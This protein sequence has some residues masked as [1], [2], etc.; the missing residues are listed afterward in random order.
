MFAARKGHV[1]AT[2]ALI[3]AGATTYFDTKECP[4][5]TRVLIDNA[6]KLKEA[7]EKAQRAAQRAAAKAAREKRRAPFLEKLKGVEKAAAEVIIKNLDKE[8][9]LAFELGL[10]MKAEGEK[11]AAEFL[12]A[13]GDIVD[14]ALFENKLTGFYEGYFTL[15]ISGKLYDLANNIVEGANKR[16]IKIR[17]KYNGTRCMVEVF[18][19]D[20]KGKDVTWY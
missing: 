5:Q 13:Q 12:L 6:K 7:A 19:V 16:E 1:E 2:R 9:E 10:V 20:D 3:E 18:D 8:N 15:Q 4:E 14:I 11:E 17:V